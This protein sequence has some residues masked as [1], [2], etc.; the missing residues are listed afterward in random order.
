MQQEKLYYGYLVLGGAQLML[1]SVGLWTEAPAVF[2]FLGIAF[3]ALGAYGLTR[4]A[5]SPATD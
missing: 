3:I 4:E 5:E 2:L 1:G